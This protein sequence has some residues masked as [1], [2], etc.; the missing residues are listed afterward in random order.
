MKIENM[1]PG[2]Q[3]WSVQR[4]KMGNTTITTVSLY[5]VRIV[6]VDL[7]DRTVTAS[8]NS[9]PQRVYREADA[10]KWRKDKPETVT[11]ITGAERL[12]RRGEK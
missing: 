7:K 2:Q 5:P 3:V 4:H 1:Q 11:S 10:K 9:N 12:K 8:W 6:S